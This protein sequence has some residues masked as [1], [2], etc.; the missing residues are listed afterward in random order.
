MI[1][2]SCFIL[3]IILPSLA[4]ANVFKANINSG[5]LVNQAIEIIPGYATI[6]ELPSDIESYALADQ[7]IFQCVKIP[8][9]MNKMM[10]KPLIGSPVETNLIIT[11]IDNEFN[12][13][14]RVGKVTSKQ[15]YFKYQFINP[16]KKYDTQ[17]YADAPRQNGSGN[18]LQGILDD[19]VYEKCVAKESSRY[20]EF[21]CLQKI[22]IGTET[23]LRFKLLNRS[24]SQTEVLKLSF[25]VQTLGGFTGLS[26]KGHSTRETEFKLKASILHAGEESFGVVSMPSIALKANERLALHVFTNYGDEGD[27]IITRF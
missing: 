7:S 16:H 2:I 13:I 23:Y 20:L 26:I 10:C 18:L 22:Q 8:P 1:K 9:G 6:I 21:D 3:V 11:T 15:Q 12:L 4:F 5:E 24:T 25:V 17:V 19:F 27:L 14:M